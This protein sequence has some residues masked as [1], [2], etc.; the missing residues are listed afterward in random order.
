MTTQ[1]KA[2]LIDWHTNLWLPEYLGA[3]YEEMG[4]RTIADMDGS[5]EAHRKGVAETAEKFI[6]LALKF[7]QLGIRV[8]NEFVAEYVAQFPGR[9]IGFCGIDPL[10]PDSPDQLEHAVKELGL[11]G[12]KFS[13][14]YSGFDP[15]CKEAWA[16]YE[17]ADRLGV[18]MLWH[19]S[20]AYPV[21]SHLEAGNPILIDK[22]ARAFPELKMII[23]HVGQPWVGELV[24]LL[25]KHHQLYA[26]LSARFHRKWQC[27]NA[28]MLALDYQVTDRLLFGSDWPLQTTQEAVDAF[29][30][31]NDWGEGVSL[32]RFPDEIIEDI[33]YNR[34]L[35]LIWPDG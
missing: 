22:I 27:Y 21:E 18:P 23:A 2:S 29:R 16:I 24:V 1:E 14:V 35:E 32:P 26:D 3:Q 19:Q 15:W 31:I 17:M 8:P 4:A 28:L 34:P 20:A 13:P 11:K 6:V 33:L 9:A 30:A 7:D 5:P 12:I 10:D 25:R